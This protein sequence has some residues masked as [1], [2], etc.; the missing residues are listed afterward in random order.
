MRNSETCTCPSGD[1]SLRWPCPLHPAL[2]PCPF[3]GA[4]ARGYEIEPHQHSAALLALA[5]N[6]PKDH[7]GS[8][9][10]EGECQCESGLIG[11]NQ[12]EV[13]ARWN[14]RAPQ[15]VAAAPASRLTMEQAEATAFSSTNEPT[16]LLRYWFR[17]GYTAAAALAE[18]QAEPVY[19]DDAAVDALAVKMKAKLAMQRA[20]GYGGWDTTECSQ[21]RLSDM[22]R[23]RVAK[24]DP[25]DVANFCAFLHAR[26][27]V[28]ASAPQAAPAALDANRLRAEIL[29]HA[30][31]ASRLVRTLFNEP[32]GTHSD[33]EVGDWIQR[34]QQYL[35]L[36]SQAAPAE[37]SEKSIAAIATLENLGYTH[38]GG[39]LWKPPLGKAPDFNLLDSLRAH[40][41][42]LEAQL[43]PQQAQPADAMEPVR[44]AVRDYHYALDD[45]QHG[46]VA[47]HKAIY[48]IEEAL[49]MHWKQ[50]LEASLRADKQDGET[51]G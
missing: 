21:Q 36:P 10:I 2:L 38:H 25:V 9:V 8:Y 7:Q 11:D 16:S 49:G 43:S 14:A 23:D 6:M 22:L 5:P 51:N 32:A 41:A 35:T 27:Q 20:K 48:A 44:Q 13:T 45:R 24:G 18:V 34:A 42:S 31:K 50:G 19:P 17:K 12:A 40:I 3:C 33:V 37:V 1:G 29:E 4:S 39:I 15:A 30:S 46:G 47:A 26:G 28:I